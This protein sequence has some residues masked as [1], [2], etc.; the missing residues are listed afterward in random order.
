MNAFEKYLLDNNYIK[1][2]S[3]FVSSKK[4][5]VLKQT[6]EETFSTMGNLHYAYVKKNHLTIK[7]ED[8]PIILTKDQINKLP[9][10]IFFGLNE[11]GKPPTLISPRPISPIKSTCINGKITFE[12]YYGDDQIN[13]VLQQVDFKDILDCVENDK[14]LKL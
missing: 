10:I 14:I 5:F 4:E 12:F 6:N 3:V 13:R 1:F 7:S 8:E 11:V 2:K 9:K